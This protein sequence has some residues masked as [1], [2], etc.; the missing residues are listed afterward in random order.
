MDRNEWAALNNSF[1][2]DNSDEDIIEGDLEAAFVDVSK[3]SVER[4]LVGK[5]ISSKINGTVTVKAVSNN[6]FLFRLLNLKDKHKVFGGGPWLLEYQLLALKVP[7][8]VGDYNLLTFNRVQIHLVLISCMTA[9]NG[10]RTWCP[11]WAG[12]RS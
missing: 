12:D 9:D 6:T 8:S 7:T 10:Q 5:L 1:H 3:D 4:T 11:S 2:Y